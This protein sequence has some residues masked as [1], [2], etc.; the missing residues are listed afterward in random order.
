MT[1]YHNPRCQK[2]R[3]TLQLIR[4]EGIQADIVEYLKTPIDEAT[5][6]NI[7]KKLGISVTELLRKNEKIYK[8]NYKGKEFS[9]AEWI[10]I[11]VANPKL[12]KRPIVVL[13]DKA[14]IGRPPT[15]IAKLLQ[16]S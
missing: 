15:N 10:R 6:Q 4:E 16:P 5:L 9:E 12:I 1:I 2:S 14:V 13:G 3:A 11:M 7:I 8:D